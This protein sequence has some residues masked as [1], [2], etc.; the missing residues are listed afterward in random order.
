MTNFN[1]RYPE[2]EAIQQHI[3]RAHAER[4][5]AVASMIAGGVAAAARAVKRL[6]DLFT[7]GIS[8]ERSLHALEVDALFKRNAAKY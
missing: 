4:S 8:A 7:T 5:V 6:G 3:R 1:N 2:Y